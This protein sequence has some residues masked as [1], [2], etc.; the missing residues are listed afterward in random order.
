MSDKPDHLED[1]SK[2]LLNGQSG[3]LKVY[4]DGDLWKHDGK[5]WICFVLL[6]ETYGTFAS[7]SELTLA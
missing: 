6:G 1:G 2:V 7:I 5:E 3:K 4:P